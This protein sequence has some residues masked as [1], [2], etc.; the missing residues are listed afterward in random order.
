MKC[1]FCEA[2][3]TKDKSCLA[4]G[5]GEVEILQALLSNGEYIWIRND[6]VLLPALPRLIE[7]GICRFKCRNGIKAHYELIASKAHVT[8]RLEKFQK[9]YIDWPSSRGR[10]DDPIV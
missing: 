7:Q 9:Q 3:I 8:G 10:I 4:C 1:Q 6:K 5:D 2:P